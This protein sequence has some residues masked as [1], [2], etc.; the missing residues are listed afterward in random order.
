MKLYF[1]PGA[2]SLSPHIVLREAG[3][4]FDLEQVDLREKK[5]K[6][7]D[8]YWKINPKGQVPLLELD[9]GQMISEGP[10]IVQYVADKNPGAGIIPA[11]GSIDR[12]HLQGWLTHIGT[13]LH[14]TYGPMFRPTT[15]DEYKKISTETLANKYKNI[16]KMLEGKQYIAVMAGNGAQPG[17][18]GR[19]APPPAAQEPTAAAAQ[20]GNARRAARARRVARRDHAHCTAGR[21]RLDPRQPPAAL[22]RRILSHPR[23]RA[24]LGDAARLD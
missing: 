19:G 22:V 15:P 24:G 1:A 3:A 13:E 14:K 9:D 6:K 18:R 5:T 2:C 8:D 23:L 7:G 11:A 17:G 12:Y 20:R 16:D 21:F 4:K 10:A